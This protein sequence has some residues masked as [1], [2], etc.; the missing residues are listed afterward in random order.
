MQIRIEMPMLMMK[1]QGLREKGE[2]WIHCTGKSA[3]V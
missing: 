2:T 3:L 1:E